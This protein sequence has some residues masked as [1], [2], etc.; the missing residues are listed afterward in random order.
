MI[1]AAALAGRKVS[2]CRVKNACLLDRLQVSP[3][4]LIKAA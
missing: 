3:A 2:W 1:C 4:G